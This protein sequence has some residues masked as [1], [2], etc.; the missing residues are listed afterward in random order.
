MSFIAMSK[1]FILQK[2]YN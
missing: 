2:T 1:H